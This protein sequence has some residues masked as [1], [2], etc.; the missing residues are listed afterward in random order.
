MSLAQPDCTATPITL[1]PRDE[2]SFSSLLK[3]AISMMQPSHQVAQKSRTTILFFRS[4]ERSVFPPSIGRAIW[5]IV[6]GCWPN[7]QT[8]STAMI[9]NVPIA[10]NG[11]ERFISW[12]Y[13]NAAKSFLTLVSNSDSFKHK[14]FGSFI[15][16]TQAAHPC[17]VP[18]F[19]RAQ[20]VANQLGHF[21]GNARVT[22]SLDFIANMVL[23][24]AKA[25]TQRNR[26]VLNFN[27]HP[28]A[29]IINGKVFATLI[30]EID[31]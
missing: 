29:Q 10:T 26:I 5:G 19:A 28:Q 23:V 30:V 1:T 11:S 14:A 25:I 2:Y 20:P 31:D 15:D 24:E 27:P 21:V 16:F 8:H 3:S 13:F 4:S 7:V 12:S 17:G 22:S 18:S 9:M 6:P